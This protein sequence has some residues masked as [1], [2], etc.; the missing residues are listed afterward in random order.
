MDAE[1]RQLNAREKDLL[2]KLLEAAIH[3]RDELRTQLNHVKAKQIENDGTLS[4]ECHGGIGAPGKYA[5]GAEGICKDDDGSDIAVLLHLGKG[6]FMSMLE[7]I[8]YGGSPIINP[9]SARDLVLLLPESP[10]QKPSKV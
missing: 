10:G 3:G 5:P 2:G 6:G 4:L 8:K 7:I 9:P 1:F